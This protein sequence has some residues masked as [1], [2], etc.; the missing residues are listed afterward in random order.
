LHEWVNTGIA[1]VALFASG[2]AAYFAHE[3]NA[4]HDEDLGLV[5]Q[6][7]FNCKMS[8][9]ATDAH[10]LK[11]CW[12]V[13][14]SNKSQ[15]KVTII[16]YRVEDEDEPS[17]RRFFAGANAFTAADG[18]P[19]T[20]PMSIEGKSGQQIV[21]NMTVKLTDAAIKYLGDLGYKAGAEFTLSDFRE[22]A[23]PFDVGAP[24]I[25]A[26]GSESQPSKAT[27]PAPA[28]MY[29]NFCATIGDATDSGDCREHIKIVLT[30]AN[31]VEFPFPVK[32]PLN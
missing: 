23:V 4:M 11:V 25:D 19:L 20:V 1:V 15:D 12:G 28:P 16:D 9:S 17:K 18:K 21:I 13:W 26:L 2:G 29:D 27:A 14:V 7:N 3:A 30:T 10:E 22:A 6:R 24:R 31:G 8:I 32:A 5:L